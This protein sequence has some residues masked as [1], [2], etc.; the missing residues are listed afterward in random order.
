MKPD[1]IH[2]DSISRVATVPD[3]RSYRE[4]HRR[5]ASWLHAPNGLAI[6]SSRLV[7]IDRATSVGVCHHLG[8]VR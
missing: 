1:L 4:L 3:C 5:L 6:G 2:S 8:A 7:A